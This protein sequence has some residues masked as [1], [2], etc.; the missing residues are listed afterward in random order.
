VQRHCNP[1]T[2]CGMAP[3]PWKTAHAKLAALAAGAE[4][5]RKSL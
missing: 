2:N 4:V 1:C 5:M 3:M